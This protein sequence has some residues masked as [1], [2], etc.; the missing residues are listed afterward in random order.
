VW[1]VVAHDLFALLAAFGNS[2]RLHPFFAPGQLVNHLVAV[3][4]GRETFRVRL[5]YEI[6]REENIRYD[7]AV[8]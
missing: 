6:R 3:L 1:P 8:A 7:E 4:E 2:P 5:S